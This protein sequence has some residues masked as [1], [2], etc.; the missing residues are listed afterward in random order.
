MDQHILTEGYA[1]LEFQPQI[2]PLESLTRKLWTKFCHL[3][4][5]H[6]LLLYHSQLQRMLH[7][8]VVTLEEESRLSASEE[9]IEKMLS[10]C[11]E[12]RCRSL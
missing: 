5:L 6:H 4:L 3:L 10:K 11:G 2:E 12:S 8:S 9:E 1:N 7:F